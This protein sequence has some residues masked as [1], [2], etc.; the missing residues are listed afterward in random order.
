MKMLFELKNKP[1]NPLKGEMIQGIACVSRAGKVLPSRQMI[2]GY[3]DSEGVAPGYSD[4]AFQANGFPPSE[5]S[6]N[7]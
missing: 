4:T 7:G 6:A 3:A 5:W 2:R 1:P